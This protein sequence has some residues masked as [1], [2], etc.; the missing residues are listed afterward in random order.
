MKQFPKL[1]YSPRQL[2]VRAVML[3]AGLFCIAFGVALSTKSG[4][5]VSP[6]AGLPYLFSHIFPVSMGTLTTLV[7]VL[8]VV[9]QIALLRRNYKPVQLLQLLVVFVFGFFTDFTISLVQPLELNGYAAR[10]L[11]CVVSCAVMAFGVFLEVKAQLLVMASEGAISAVSQVFHL[12][13]GK[14]KMGLDLS[15]VVLSAAVSLVWY[16]RLEGIRE[17]TIIAAVLVGML[18]HVYQLRLT[19]VDSLLQGKGFSR[20]KAPA[21]SSSAAPLV[22]TIERELGTGGHELGERIAKELGLAFYDYAVI[23]K[24]AE[25]TGIQ[26]SEVRD[27]E[28]RLSG[29]LLDGLYRN[30]YAVSQARSKQDLIFE[31]QGRVIRGMADGGSC[32][33]VGRLGSYVL[34][35]RPNCFHVFLSGSLAY[36]AGRIAK[37]DHS[38]TE[39][40]MQRLAR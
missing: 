15:F 26:L 7:N 37:E 40:A 32:V 29:N 24:T 3:V 17:G 20:R 4:L 8:F 36:R 16:H 14:V 12:D 25:T 34:R 19:F 28:E 6:S 1:K 23:E 9:A 38:T 11:L 13:F 2:L 35:D 10:L 18:V 33:I 5:G 21:A 30:S 31:A 22:I 39:Q 27:R